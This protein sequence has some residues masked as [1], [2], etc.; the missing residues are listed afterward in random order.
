M[1][2]FRTKLRVPPH[3]IPPNIRGNPTLG[4]PVK[5][6]EHSRSPMDDPGVPSPEEQLRIFAEKEGPQGQPLISHV[7]H[8]V[9]VEWMLKWKAF[10][11]VSNPTQRLHPGPIKTAALAAAD[12]PIAI[13]RDKVG[14]LE[15]RS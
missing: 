7:Y 9:P 8:A 15:M 1:V 13:G 3:N 12:D 11:D 6:I 10:C 2:N 4:L 5:A 14:L